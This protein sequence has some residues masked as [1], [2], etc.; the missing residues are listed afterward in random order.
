MVTVDKLSRGK[1]RTN[2]SEYDSS[3]RR[4]AVVA[5][6]MLVLSHGKKDDF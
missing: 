5:R 3:W 6:S 4:Q 1:I 2:G